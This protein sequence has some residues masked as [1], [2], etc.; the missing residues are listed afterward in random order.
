MLAY[1]PMKRLLAALCAAAAS[2]LACANDPPPGT[3]GK[4]SA[5]LER[6]G[7]HEECVRL[8]AGESRH[9]YWRATGPIDFN[10]HFH[11]GDEVTYPVKREAMRGDGGT[12]TAKSGED[13]CWTWSARDR[14]VKLEGRI[15]D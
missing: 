3:P 9:Y 4:F 10:I 8:E 6:G 11:R 14:A 1:R 12:F 2:T 13:Y 7:E 15:K 5:S